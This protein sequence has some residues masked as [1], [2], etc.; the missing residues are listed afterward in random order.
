[1][2]GPV[3]A[4][5]APRGDLVSDPAGRTDVL[6]R[7]DRR[8]QV[9]AG[10]GGVGRSVVAATLARRLAARGHR[11]L[12]LEVNAPDSAARFLGVEPAVDVPR[13][14]LDG[15]FLCRMTPAGAMK[16]Y[17]LL[18]LR[19]KAL[20]QLVFENRLVKYL[21]RSIPSLAE[22]T[23]MGKVWYHATERGPDG[24]PRFDRIVLDAPATGHAITML[25]VSRLV[26]DTVPGGPMRDAAEKMA[27]L[28]E[29]ASDACLHLVT[30]PEEMPVT[31]ALELDAQ[32]GARLRMAAGIGIVNRCRPAL[33]APGEHALVD[34]LAASADPRV[35]PFVAT[36]RG[37]SFRESL[38]AEHRAR[39]VRGLG[40]PVITLPE[41]SGQD[42]VALTDTLTAALD[43]ALGDAPARRETP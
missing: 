10:K 1:M 5:D 2:D 30:L 35:A 22:F 27:A 7:L 11:T 31:E 21:L 16:E 8:F 43:A 18:V 38:E 19:F 24:R 42:G 26:A 9:V 23:M 32:R 20:Y 3:A 17:A 37:R 33:L 4:A 14:V 36:A 28:V 6:R 15:L 25:A 41:A 29:D 12:L 39:F 34:A 40:A 13:E